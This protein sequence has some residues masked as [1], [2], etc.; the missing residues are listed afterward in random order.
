MAGSADSDAPAQQLPREELV[1]GPELVQALPMHPNDAV[2]RL[3]AP[4]AAEAGAARAPS[5][6]SRPM[7]NNTWTYADLFAEHDPTPAFV[8]EIE[9]LGLL[10]VVARDGEGKAIYS[11]GA[12]DALDR[13]MALVDAGYSPRDIAVI[14]NKVGLKPPRRRLRRAPVMHRASAVAEQVGVEAAQVTAWHAAGLLEASHVSERGE[15]LF[16]PEAL[17]VA[18]ALA[19][20]RAL[21]LPDEAAARWVDL[22]RRLATAREPERVRTLVLDAGELFASVRE[23][24]DERR[25]AAR[26]WQKLLVAFEK[27]LERARRAVAP[28]VPPLKTPSRLRRRSR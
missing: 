3:R 12:R 9:R 6:S 13:V 16:G 8:A 7:P 26:R 15:V 27:R 17:G 14:A 24:A 2:R 22:N 25:R 11:A 23:A 4:H 18:Q 1:E 20:L 21:G 5:L 28:N 19:D 10:Q